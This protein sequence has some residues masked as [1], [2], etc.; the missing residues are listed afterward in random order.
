MR[1]QFGTS[2]PAGGAWISAAWCVCFSELLL[3]QVDGAVVGFDGL[4]SSRWTSSW[5][6]AV[7]VVL[8]AVR[9][10][11]AVGVVDRRGTGVVERGGCWRGAC[12]LLVS[13]VGCCAVAGGQ[14]LGRA[15]SRDDAASGFVGGETGRA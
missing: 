12:V 8:G 2:L 13:C 14:L 5:L 1:S 15:V 11:R 10:V 6:A 3:R 9:G 4:C 7:R